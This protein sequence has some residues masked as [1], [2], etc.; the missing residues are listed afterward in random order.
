MLSSYKKL[1]LESFLCAPSLIAMSSDKKDECTSNF[2]SI[3]K[4]WLVDW[5]QTY[6][7]KS[8]FDKDFCPLLNLLLK[9][10][11]APSYPSAKHKTSQVTRF[12]RV[13]SFI[14]IKK[15]I[16]GTR[17]SHFRFQ[18]AS[19]DYRATAVHFLPQESCFQSC[20]NLFYFHRQPFVFLWSWISL[21]RVWLSLH[22]RVWIH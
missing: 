21:D 14:I 18:A 7:Q 19:P 12:L 1:H 17:H 6:S 8:I 13:D 9:F 10:A 15:E 11:R 16:L 20:R 5:R 22:Q 4:D 2:L 3:C